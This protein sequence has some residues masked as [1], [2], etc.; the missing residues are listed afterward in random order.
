MNNK[1]FS[2]AIHGGKLRIEYVR[3]NKPLEQGYGLKEYKFDIPSEL[4]NETT[5][6]SEFISGKIKEFD[7]QVLRLICDGA[8][9]FALPEVYFTAIGDVGTYVGG[10]MC[11]PLSCEIMGGA[12]C[13]ARQADA[14]NTSNTSSTIYGVTIVVYYK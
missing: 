3:L 1:I 13:F 11:V 5:K 10:Y 8:N 2:L 6:I 4:N 7:L 14:S 9:R 12:H